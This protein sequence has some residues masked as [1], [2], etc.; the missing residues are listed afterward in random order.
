M[1]MEKKLQ[2]KELEWIA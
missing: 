1:I 2:V